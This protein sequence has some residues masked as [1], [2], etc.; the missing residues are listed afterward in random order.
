MSGK[1]VTAQMQNA[2]SDGVRGA[3]S[4]KRGTAQMQ[5]TISDGSIVI[6]IG[7]PQA[8]WLLVVVIAIILLIAMLYRPRRH[9]NSVAKCAKKEPPLSYQEAKALELAEMP[10]WRLDPQGGYIRIPAPPEEVN[11]HGAPTQLPSWAES[12]LASAEEQAIIKTARKELQSEVVPAP[13]FLDIQLLRQLRALGDT[14]TAAQLAQKYRLCWRWKQEN[15]R[16][17]ATESLY[18]GSD[19][20][21]PSQAELTHGE[22]FTQHAIAGLRCGRSLGGHQVK[23]ERGGLHNFDE[24]NRTPDGYVRACEHYFHLLESLE[25]SL[26]SE[27]VA[28]G[29]LLRD[30]EV[31][32]FKGLSF[33]NCNVTT[34]RITARLAAA[35]TQNYPETIAKTAVI[36]LPS[37]ATHAHCARSMHRHA[38]VRT[39][40]TNYGVRSVRCVSAS[41]VG[42]TTYEHA[43][44]CDARAC[45]GPRVPP[46]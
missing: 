12:P 26:D 28:C 19:G 11:G 44:Q 21:W 27:S 4:G 31:F 1:R 41:Q 10:G 40:L 42:R 2:I 6:V 29:R 22:W 15:L 7:R 24:M 39:T 16:H 18:P 43:D 34:L 17:I 5:N 20:K 14:A 46:A 25:Y 32:D 38:P 30:Y 9:S 35:F 23:I 37:C 33:K 8:W 36:N 3:M 13:E 45:Q